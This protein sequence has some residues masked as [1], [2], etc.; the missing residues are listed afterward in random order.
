MRELESSL[1]ELTKLS[2]EFVN[3]S[4]PNISAV[5]DTSTIIVQG[6]TPIGSP[7][8]ALTSKRIKV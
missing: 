7:S 6:Q 3:L 4:P 1:N 8:P 2:P 5:E